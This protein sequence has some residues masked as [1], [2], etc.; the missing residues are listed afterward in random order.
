[1]RRM[2][3]ALICT[4]GVWAMPSVAEA[5]TV[6]LDSGIPGTTFAF[7]EFTFDALA[8]TTYDGQTVALDIQFDDVLVAAAFSINLFLSQ[9]APLGT[10]PTTGLTVTGYLLDSDGNALGD[11]V[12]WRLVGEMPAQIWPGGPLLP[13]ATVYELD[14]MGA[15]IPDPPYDYLIDPLIVSGIHL[16]ISL[17]NS[18]DSLIGSRLTLANFKFPISVAPDPIPT[19]RVNVPDAGSTRF[20]LTVGIGALFA[21]RH[22]RRVSRPHDD[23]AAA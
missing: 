22:A 17:P 4:A 1:M 5:I 8:G 11:A 13:A 21:Y 7:R 6:G 12:N 2:L 15:I 19:Y 9:E 14:Q 16:D 10:W 18:G 23:R 3:S 20:L